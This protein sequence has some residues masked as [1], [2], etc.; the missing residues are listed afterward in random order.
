QAHPGL[1]VT[2]DD[3]GL[4]VLPLFHIFGLN[5]VLDLALFGGASVLLVERFDPV[6]TLDVVRENAVTIVAGAPPIFAA[7]AGLPG[8]D[9]GALASVRLAVSGGAPLPEEVDEAFRSRFGLPVWQGYG[10]TET[11]PIVSSS[12]VGGEPRPGSIGLPLPG[13]E[14]RLVDE[15]GED[16]LAGDSGEIW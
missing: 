11:A 15:E 13:V 7:W 6:S 12:L 4:G 5:A 9:R 8:A 10:L 3:V 14:V 16:A 1:A 2:P